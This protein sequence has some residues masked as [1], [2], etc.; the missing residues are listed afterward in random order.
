VK[1]FYREVGTLALQGGFAVALD[2]KPIKTVGGRPQVVPSQALA[3]AMAQE[4]AAQGD[5]LDLGLFILRDLADYALDVVASEREATLANLLRYA[6]TDTLCYRAAPDEPLHARQLAMWEPVLSAAEA[7]HGV[8]FAR[9]SGII[10]KPQPGPTLASLRAVLNQHD[11]FALAGLTTLASLAASLVVALA[12]LQPDA[13][14][15]SLWAA[16]SLEEEWQADQWGREE[17]AE[18]RRIRRAGHFATAA[19][20]VALARG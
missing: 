2:G 18:E 11:A 8:S 19:R 3:Q 9:V 12:V 6:E 17:E 20:F 14:V 16:A 13:D 15:D 7:R 5:T 1:R 4:W 10:H